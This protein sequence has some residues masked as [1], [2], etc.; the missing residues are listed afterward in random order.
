MEAGRFNELLDIL[1]SNSVDTL[2]TKNAKYSQNGDCLH[3]FRAG[4]EITGMTLAQTCWGYLAKHLTALRDYIEKDDFNDIDDFLE[5]CQDTINYVRFLW[6]IGNETYEGYTAC[7][8][9]DVDLQTDSDKEYLKAADQELVY[10][11]NHTRV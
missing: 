6:C 9:S 3:N 2:K 4:S 10:P 8:S 1:E 7:N 5:K 11:D